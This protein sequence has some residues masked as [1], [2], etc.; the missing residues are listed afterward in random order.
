[1]LHQFCTHYI[2]LV[3]DLFCFSNE[4]VCYLTKFIA[5]ES[6]L[7]NYYKNLVVCVCVTLEY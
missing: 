3:C 6:T 2:G 1:M 5:L 4:A 7:V